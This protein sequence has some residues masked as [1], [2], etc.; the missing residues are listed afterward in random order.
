M[1]VTVRCIIAPIADFKPEVGE[2]KVAVDW[3][4]M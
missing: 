4:L 2:L 1:A 3:P